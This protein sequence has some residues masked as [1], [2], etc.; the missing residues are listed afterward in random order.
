MINSVIAI[1]LAAQATGTITGV[2][3]TKATGLKP[4]RVTMDQR[5]CGDELPDEAVVVN[6]QGGL[7]NA[8]VTLA[9]VKSGGNAKTSGIT[10]QKCRFVPR[11]QRNRKKAT[12]CIQDTDVSPT[13]RIPYGQ[14]MVLT[15]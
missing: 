1:L 7:A 15:R 11:V 12:R 8:V 5:V 10:N 4:L 14:D 6:A 9:G 2:I 3:T 13:G